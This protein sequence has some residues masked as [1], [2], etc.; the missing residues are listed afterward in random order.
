MMMMMMIIII[1]IQFSGE[2]SALYSNHTILI[3]GFCIF[4][5]TV[6]YNMYNKNSRI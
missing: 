5:P 1:I 2:T 6:L 4:Y 3:N